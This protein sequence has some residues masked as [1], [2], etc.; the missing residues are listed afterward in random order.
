MRV[1]PGNR[2][3]QKSHTLK[4]VLDSLLDVSSR[5]FPSWRTTSRTLMGSGLSC[6]PGCESSSQKMRMRTRTPD[7]GAWKPQPRDSFIL[8]LLWCSSAVSLLLVYWGVT[9]SGYERPP[10]SSR[11][12]EDD[13]GELEVLRIIIK[14]LLSGTH[15]W[16][17][18]KGAGEHYERWRNVIQLLRYHIYFSDVYKYK[19]T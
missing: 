18:F 7:S 8:W 16:G 12:D 13:V 5:T 15:R 2:S 6:S 1:S 17:A 11:T 14:P 4:Y 3:M 19:I 10:S 9:M